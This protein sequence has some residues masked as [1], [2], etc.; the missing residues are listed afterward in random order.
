M[1]RPVEPIELDTI[2]PAPPSPAHSRPATPSSLKAPTSSYPPSEILPSN[3]NGFS[4]TETTRQSSL[5]SLNLEYGEGTAVS[6]PP[7]D[8]GRGAWQ[9]VV[10]AFILE[11]WGYSYSF[12]TI[13][14][15]LQSTPPWSSSSLSALSAI[16]SCQLGIQFCLPIAI[17]IVFRRYPDWVKTSLWVSLVVN[18]GSM[19]L[20]SWA[21]KVWQLIVLQGVVCGTAGAILYAPVLIWLTEWFHERRGL[22]GG[23]IWSGTGIGG[24]LFPF[25]I[26]GLLSKVGFAWM[27]RVWSL[28]TAVV[29]AFSLYIVKPRIPPPRV[30]KGERG[31]WPAFPWKVLI[32]PVFVTMAIASLFASLSTF[33]VSLYLATYASSLTTSTFVAEIVV[34]IYNVAASV[35]CTV[36]GYVS[37]WSYTAATIL[38]GVLGTIIALFAWGWADTLAK[39]YGFAV[40]FGFSSQ[41]IVAWSGATR[42]VAG[43]DPYA[44][45]ITFCLLSS[46]RGIA[47]IVMPLVSQG[48]YNPKLKNDATSWGRFGFEKMIVFVGVTAF[49]SAI[50]GVALEYMRRKHKKA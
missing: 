27:I 34:G 3:G 37:D 16:G 48:L 10:A 24:F 40:L 23:I 47:S 18:C 46:V 50:A 42:D 17:V 22:A 1:T 20:S 4:T 7:M 45:A 32:D 19:L 25:L 49:V 15:Y 41:M 12:A 2:T 26:S 44:A 29:F 9:F 13:L 28:L 31:P 14:V 35:G 36:L 8:R 43:Q 6:L 38:C 30:R 33:P 39:T 21:T 11:C 5:R